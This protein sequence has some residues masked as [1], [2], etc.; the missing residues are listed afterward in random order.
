M[1]FPEVFHISNW[2]A[3]FNIIQ[4]HGSSELRTVRCQYKKMK[5]R[6]WDSYWTKSRTHATSPYFIGMSQGAYMRG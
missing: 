2:I 5:L 4:S 1:F 6:P 3:L